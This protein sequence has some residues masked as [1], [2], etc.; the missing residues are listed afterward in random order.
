MP[1]GTVPTV[2]EAEE[3]LAALRAHGPAP[4]AFTLREA[5]RRPVRN[6]QDGRHRDRARAVRPARPPVAIS[7]PRAIQ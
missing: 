1:A 3:R 2:A 4:R 5:F 6:P 7:V